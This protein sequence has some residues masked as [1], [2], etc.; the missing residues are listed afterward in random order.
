MALINLPTDHLRHTRWAQEWI[1]EG[2]QEGEARGEARGRAAE[3]A[4]M[5]IRQLNHRCGPLSEATT[6]HIQALPLQQ[7]EALTDALLDFAGA[8]DLAS[9]LA[10]HAG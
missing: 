8:D 2:R 5:A 6:A 4:A 3:A 7:L 1:E 9:W 10:E